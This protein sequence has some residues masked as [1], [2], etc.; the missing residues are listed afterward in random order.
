MMEARKLLMTQRTR[1]RKKPVPEPKN[2][3]MAMGPTIGLMVVC[4][5]GIVCMFLWTTRHATAPVAA[6]PARSAPAYTP[7]HIYSETANPSS[8]IAAALA[9]AKREHKRVLLDFGGDWCGDCQALDI[10]FH[11]PPNDA[12]LADHF[13]L[14]HVWIGHE[15]ANLDVAKRYGVPIGKGVPALA[16][17]DA[18]GRLLYAQ[19]AGEF[20]D[21]RHM[22]PASVTEFLETWKS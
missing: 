5:A 3:P 11:Q 19:K 1:F 4:L 2:T 14:V 16:V 15:D 21:M 7:K 8:D 20:E 6:Q 12:L 10:Y 9:Q 18:D 22:E 17:L 13:V